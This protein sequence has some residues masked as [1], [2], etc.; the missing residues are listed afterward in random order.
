MIQTVFLD[1]DNTLLDFNE[2]A[3]VSAQKAFRDM[4]LE[5]HDGVFP[6]FI[7]ENDKLWLKIEDGTLSREELH[8]IRWQLIFD[9]LQIDADG[10][11]MEKLFLQYIEESLVLM[12]G[13]LDLLTYLSSRYT[14]CLASNAPEQQQ[15]KRLARTPIPPLVDHVFLSETLGAVKPEKAFWDACFAQLP[16][17]TPE[18]SVIIGDSLS[19]DIRGSISYGMKACWFNPNHLPAPEAYKIDYIVHSLSEIQNIL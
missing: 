2:C 17:A 8:R 12:D 10:I 15:L 3:K 5:Y 7:E 9:R 18:N 16:G 4:K 1:I 13:A 6:V 19:A 14:V 11:S